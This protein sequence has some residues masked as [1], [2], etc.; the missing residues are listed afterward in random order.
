MV[1]SPQSLPKPDTNQEYPA[2]A[3]NNNV[4]LLD[5]YH[6]LS[7]SF[8]LL[9]KLFSQSLKNF[10]FCPIAL[11]WIDADWLKEKQP[12]NVLLRGLEITDVICSLCKREQDMKKP[13]HV[14]KEKD[15][16]EM[17]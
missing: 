11:I 7:H 3:T 17:I 8:F 10:K 1:T 5:S 14:L 15:E 2:G 9:Q 4:V 13:N 12:K 6:Y 16:D